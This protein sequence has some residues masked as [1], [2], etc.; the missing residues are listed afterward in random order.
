MLTMP[1]C[2]PFQKDWKSLVWVSIL[3]IASSVIPYPTKLTRFLE[4]AQDKLGIVNT[5]AYKDRLHLK[6]FG[7]DILHRINQDA[8]IDLGIMPGDAIHL[9]DNA[10]KWW[11]SAAAKHKH[12]SVDKPTINSTPPNKHIQFEKHYHDGGKAILWGSK[13]VECNFDS[14]GTN[15]QWHYHSYAHDAVVPIPPGYAPLFKDSDD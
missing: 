1:K 6:G 12:A 11:N 5:P 13:L 2:I 14:H 4:Y 9:Q 15:F 10:L 8:L 3:L 7:P